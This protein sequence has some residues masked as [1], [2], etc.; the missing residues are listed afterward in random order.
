MN[1]SYQ[2]KKLFIIL[3]FIVIVLLVVKP[4]GSASDKKLPVIDG[5]IAVATVN[6]DPITM[7]ELNRAIAASHARRSE[8]KKAGRKI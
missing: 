3:K 6:N 8:E 5:K 4:H 1:K 2:I 7:E